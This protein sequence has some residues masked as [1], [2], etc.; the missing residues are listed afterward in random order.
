MMGITGAF[1]SL[2]INERSHIPQDN[3]PG[4]GK[5]P[6]NHST[7]SLPNLVSPDSP[8]SVNF[9]RTNY[10]GCNC[11]DETEPS[12]QPVDFSKKYCETKQLKNPRNCTFNKVVKSYH[13][14]FTMYAETDLDQPTDYSLRYAE[15]DSDSDQCNKITKTETG[16]FVQDTIKTY[17]T[18]DT[19]YETPFNFST[20]TSMS[21]LRIDDKAPLKSKD[22]TVIN[23]EIAP[24]KIKSEFS[25][26][27]MSPEK[28]VNY[29]E[30]GTPGYF[31]RV[32]SCGS[33]NS[34]PKPELKEEETLIEKKETREPKA[35]K[36]EEVVNYAEETP[37]M[38]SRTSSLASLDSIEQH[39]IHDDR[40]SVVSDFSRLTSGLI[41]PSELPDSPSQTVPPS[42]KPRKHPRRKTV[43]KSSV[44]EDAVKKFETERT[45][46]HFSTATSLS[47]LIDDEID[48]KTGEVGNSGK[49]AEPV[50][51]NLSESSED[52]GILAACI[53]IGMQNN[54]YS[55]PKA[56]PPP[57]NDLPP[58]YKF[59]KKDE[60]IEK[61]DITCDSVKTYCTEDTPAILSHAG[62]NS[63]LSNL[64]L[65]GKSERNEILEVDPG[66]SHDNRV[67]GP[68]TLEI[69]TT[70]SPPSRR[71]SFS[72]SDD[73]DE[74][75]E[76]LLQECILAGMPS[77]PSISGPSD[78]P[79]NLSNPDLELNQSSD[80][81]D[82]ILTDCIN[83]GI[84]KNRY[85][86]PQIVNDSVKN[87]CTEDTPAILSHAGSCS[88]L[89]TLSIQNGGEKEYFSDLSNFSDE[90]D[91]K[92]L[93][94]CV[95]FGMAVIAKNK[96]NHEKFGEASRTPKKSEF[97]LEGNFSDSD[98]EESEQALL[99]QCIEAGMPKRPQSPDLT[100]AEKALLEQCI[101][102][103]MKKCRSIPKKPFEDDSSEL[104]EAEQALLRQCILSG[105]PK[106]KNL[107]QG[108]PSAVKESH[109]LSEA[110]RVL[111]Q[112]CILAGMPK[113]RRRKGK[114]DR[115]EHT[116]CVHCPRNKGARRKKYK[117]KESRDV[118]ILYVTSQILV[119]KEVVDRG[120]EEWV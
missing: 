53:N 57:P 108:G 9:L 36:F 30:E 43:P 78:V 59:S 55:Q 82:K 80:E 56:T 106:N 79:K 21:D 71:S 31:S 74:S 120:H 77:Q 76:A 38:F 37:L 84:T 98:S 103:G 60:I 118:N 11:D 29:C 69:P 28:P 115:Q 51:D 100:P 33:L 87:Y 116:C 91:E 90:E 44:F 68:K 95:K 26:G 119:K 97:S 19:P 5:F 111:L 14:S 41:S 70:G 12:E 39:S 64:S 15:D 99:Q 94:E 89:S 67:S 83:I 45:P 46:S 2:G 25:S 42:P 117:V 65:L 6:K 105:M 54:R 73:S 40:S 20:S 1:S 107:T 35:V 86:Q 24:P 8:V 61:S 48:A 85:T 109:E 32:P 7:L 3:S 88:D 102:E 72:L 16:E 75:G 110:E 62:S 52:E 104:T 10:S 114:E 49:E 22:V 4:R 27:L 93:E 96:F 66:P 63:D 34:I 92:L 23:K 112:Q 113:S 18:E 47:S 17:C 101:L 81:D 50:L 13:N 58:N